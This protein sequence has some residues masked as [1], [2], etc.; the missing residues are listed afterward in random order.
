M[1]PRWPK[2][3]ILILAGALL[4][5]M[6]LARA[7][8]G[9]TEPATTQTA[10]LG[11]DVVVLKDLVAQYEPVPFDHR[12]HAAMAQ[13][14]GG[15][16]TCHHR[17]PHPATEPS[18]QPALVENVVHTQDDAATI[19][20]CKSCHRLSEQAAT[21][22]MPSLKGA[23]HRQCL[24][25]HREWAHENACGACH[26]P[27]ASPAPRHVVAAAT[28]P[29]PDDIVGRMHPP[30][31]AP[32]EKLYV[33]RFTP[34]VG[35]N[36]IFRHEQHTE[37]FGVRCVG[38]HRDDS[39]SHCH[40]PRLDGATAKKPL[41]PGRSWRDTHGPCVACHADNHCDS[42]HYKDGQ[43][44]P[45]PFEHAMTGQTLDKDH[46]SLRCNQC[47][48]QLKTTAAPTCGDA[49]CHAEHPDVSFPQDRPGDVVAATRPARG[50]RQLAEEQEV[51]IASATQPVTRPSIV[52]IRR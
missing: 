36:V 5:L 48:A 40:D 14:A 19:P 41:R 31:P 30:I 37:R 45:A 7:R 24:N 4:V 51:D 28:A 3:V 32:K 26:Q 39:C 17:P 50:L 33:T 12:S 47:H 1:M 20:A 27:L 46:A 8:G 35:G 16:T 38:C 29:S 6:V 23:Y 9:Q 15:C 21:I 44:P 25:C 52:R 43:E 34:A 2:F 18:S 10:P 11:P 42:C 13:M 22:R 49:S